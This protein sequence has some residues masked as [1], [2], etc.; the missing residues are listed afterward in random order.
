[1]LISQPPTTD[2]QSSDEGDEMGSNKQRDRCT[3]ACRDLSP[4]GALTVE[5]RHSV[6]ELRDSGLA[7]GEGE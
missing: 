4:A 3:S 2:Q 6:K 5:R 7:V 1:M